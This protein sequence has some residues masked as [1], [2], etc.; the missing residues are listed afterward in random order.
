MDPLTLEKLKKTGC[1]NCPRC[2]RAV[3]LMSGCSHI[4]CPCGVHFCYNCGQSLVDCPGSEECLE[5]PAT[6]GDDEDGDDDEDD[7]EEDD[8]YD[9]HDGD[10]YGPDEPYPFSK[11]GEGN[12]GNEDG[13]GNGGAN[14]ASADDQSGPNQGAS[15]PQAENGTPHRTNH[16]TPADR[17][18]IAFLN[19]TPSPPVVGAIE[20]LFSLDPLPAFLQPSAIPDDVDLDLFENSSILDLGLDPDEL[21]PYQ[22]QHRTWSK[23]SPRASYWHQQ[24]PIICQW[25]KKAVAK[26]PDN[27]SSSAASSSSSK[28]TPPADVDPAQGIVCTMCYRIACMQCGIKLGVFINK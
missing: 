14:D 27:N 9:D 10:E 8:G 1:K 6:I 23:I 15:R 13:E 4:R 26:P 17:M 11:D 3:R 19:N 24:E 12:K 25:C 16:T 7:D 18:S 20:A 28:Q 21:Q 22:C 2:H 5:D